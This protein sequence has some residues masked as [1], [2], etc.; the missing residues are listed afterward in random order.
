MTFLEPRIESRQMSEVI[1]TQDP[2]QFKSQSA[3]LSTLLI[4]KLEE[5]RN[6]E[7]AFWSCREKINEYTF[8]P[9]PWEMINEKEY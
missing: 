8:L 6:K 2:V 1:I 5:S 3:V 4:V 7:L 9:A